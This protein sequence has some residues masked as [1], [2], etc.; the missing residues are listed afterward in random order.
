MFVLKLYRIRCIPTQTAINVRFLVVW[1]CF[2]ICWRSIKKIIKRLWRTTCVD[3]YWLIDRNYFHWL[4]V[5][6]TR[7]LFEQIFVSNWWAKIGTLYVLLILNW[8]VW[9]WL[10]LNA[11]GRLNTCKSSERKVACYLNLAADGWVI[12]R[13]LPISG[14]QHSERDANTAYALR[15]KAGDLRTLR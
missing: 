8:R 2:L 12:L 6:I 5:E 3:F 11:G 10:R 14:G 4:K 9:S 15:G 7:S 1:C 13:N